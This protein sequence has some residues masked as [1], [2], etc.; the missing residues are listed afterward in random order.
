MSMVDLYEIGI[1]F[2]I[3]RDIFGDVETLQTGMTT[4]QQAIELVN[5]SLVT[6]SE[7]L[8]SISGIAGGLATSFE[9]AATA[10]E[11][12]SAA[13]AHMS[14]A[15][16]VV[17]PAPMAPA[18]DGGM[19]YAPAAPEPETAP[20]IPRDAGTP[21]VPAVIPGQPY[22]SG[23]DGQTFTRPNYK[24]NWTYGGNG[25]DGAAPPDEP[26]PPGG[27]PAAGPAH[28]GNPWDYII[29]GSLAYE[30]GKSIVTSAYDNAAAVQHQAIQMENMGGATKDQGT[31]AINAAQALQ[32]KYPGLT[33]A[34]AMIIIRDAYM[35]TRN[36]PEA[37]K[38]ADSL[39]EA[40]YVMQ[41][42][43]DDD[44]AEA[45]FSVSRS[46]EMRGLL[47]QKNPDGSVNMA[48][49]ESF[50]DAYTRTA[51]STGGRVTPQDALTVLKNAGPEGLMMDQD[52]MTDA[53]VLSTTMG[54]SGV[55]TGLNALATQFLGGKMSQGAAQNLHRAG[56][57]P[58]YMFD[59]DGKILNKYKNGLGNVLLP[60]GALDNE[61]EFQKNPFEWVEDTF[62]PAVAKMDPGSQ[63]ALLNSIYA[64]MS[65]IPGGRLAAETIF[66]QGFLERQIGFLDGVPSVGTAAGNLKNDPQNVATGFSAAFDAFMAQV[67]GDAMPVATTQLKDLTGALNGLT[68]FF[69]DHPDVGG[70][71]FR[72]A[73]ATVAAGGAAILAG[74]IK[75]I[76]KSLGLGGKGGADGGEDASFAEAGAGD[77][78]AGDGALS[79]GGIGGS[80]AAGAVT[81]GPVGAAAAIA[82]M[83]AAT[84][85]A[86]L[87]NK[88]GID[89]TV[90]TGEYIDTSGWSSTKGPI[91]VMIVPAPG[92]QSL[93]VQVTN[94]HDIANGA[95]GHLSQ[96]Y[97]LM[98]TGPNGV[99]YDL[100]P[101]LPGSGTFGG[102]QP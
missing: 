94:P 78:A 9:S 87:Y 16:Q 46:G 34:N 5:G 19:P 73:E 68:G 3:E 12:M 7:M 79:L 2:M 100:S 58:D 85:I 30:G 65:R 96:Q 71:V 86:A 83:A 89:P 26:T 91:P 1:S 22:Y 72:G 66:Q 53:L 59:K 39:A 81:G 8:G 38:V 42:F 95:I 54:A 97:G 4:L 11:R 90:M 48:G 63:T 49:F 32:Q 37:L 35:Q 20:Q 101:P 23:D 77:A 84:K 27:G 33:Q 61:A 52:A 41:G 40:A 43:G 74:A 99:N 18:G 69:H 70:V 57:L 13:A 51:I 15:G 102:I 92:G 31:Q 50:I 67:G 93:P 47:N 29:A 17:T 24:P 82:L 44:A 6:T 80:G 64:D 45:M 60:N 88:M 56:L 75:W 10:A 98:P 25:G 21:G 28:Q 62:E 36:M 76:T 14:A 55:G